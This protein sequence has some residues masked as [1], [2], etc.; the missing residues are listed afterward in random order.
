MLA[1]ILKSSVATQVSIAIMD[2]FV[3]MRKYINNLVIKYDEDIKLLQ[4][5]FNKLED[6]MIKTCLIKCVLA[7]MK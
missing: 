1:T 3:L 4:E 2:A 6:E 7:I 5:S